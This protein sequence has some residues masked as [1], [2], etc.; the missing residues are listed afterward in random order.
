[1]RVI[2]HIASQNSEVRFLLRDLET[3]IFGFSREYLE[4][5]VSGALHLLRGADLISAA[6]FGVAMN[7]LFALDKGVQV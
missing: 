6:E 5:R 4:G 3:G 2:D 7:D 1:M